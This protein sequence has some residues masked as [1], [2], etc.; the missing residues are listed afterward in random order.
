MSSLVKFSVWRVGETDEDAAQR[1]ALAPV[2]SGRRFTRTAV[3]EL[4]RERRRRVQRYGRLGLFRSNRDLVYALNCPPAISSYSPIT[5]ACRD[6]KTCPFCWARLVAR[7]VYVRAERALYRSAESTR[8]SPVSGEIES[9]LPFPADIVDIQR[10]QYFARTDDLVRVFP[11]LYNAFHARYLSKVFGTKM[12]G[13]VGIMTVEPI[14]DGGWRAIGRLMAIV[15]PSFSSQKLPKQTKTVVCNRLRYGLAI[16]DTAGQFILECSRSS[17]TKIVGRVCQFPIGMLRQPEERVVDL[18]QLYPKNSGRA[19]RTIEYY[20]I[21]RN[22]M[23]S[24]G[25]V[26]ST[27]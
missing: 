1:R 9:D 16:D 22:V 26:S 11:N 20:G 18:L 24:R 5:R 19:L 3:R 13:A 17:L 12:L 27:P 14:D 21:L 10:S 7:E 8:V 15:D 2:W 23:S 4:I 6:R 25:V